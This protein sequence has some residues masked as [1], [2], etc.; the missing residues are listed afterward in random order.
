MYAFLSPNSKY[1][2]IVSVSLNASQVDSL[3]RILRLHGKAI[4]YTLVDITT[5]HPSMCM[6]H[7]LMEDDHNSSIEHHRRLNPNIKDVVKKGI[8]K[9]LKASVI[10]RISNSKWVSLSMS[11]LKRM[12]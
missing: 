6:H 10:Y 8:L 5:I 1:H 2:L 12:E 9:L 7:I 3:R 4:G 11:F